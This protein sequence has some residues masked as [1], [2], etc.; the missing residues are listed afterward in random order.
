[1]VEL[2]DAVDDISPTNEEAS[3][4][5]EDVPTVNGAE[6]SM[7]RGAPAGKRLTW[8]VCAVHA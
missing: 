8:T 7:G 5:A 3:T 2:K 6:V 1:M 4:A